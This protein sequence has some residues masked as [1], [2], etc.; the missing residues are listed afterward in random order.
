MQSQDV[1]VR[2]RGSDVSR[3]V[4]APLHCHPPYSWGRSERGEQPVVAKAALS[5]QQDTRLLSVFRVQAAK[6]RQLNFLFFQP[7]RRLYGK[8]PADVL[9]CLLNS[10]HSAS[11]QNAVNHQIPVCLQT[12]QWI[13][14][15]PHVILTWSHLTHTPKQWQG[16]NAVKHFFLC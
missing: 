5:L 1:S 16:E 10:L 6:G 11:V 13:K 8:C 3:G 12:T 9:E 14:N 2:T 7:T 4:P 15:A